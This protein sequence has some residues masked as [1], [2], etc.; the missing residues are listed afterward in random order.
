MVVT[1]SLTSILASYDRPSLPCND[2]LTPGLTQRLWQKYSHQM[3]KVFSPNVKSVL[4][5]C[6][7]NATLL[8]FPLS[9]TY[10]RLKESKNQRISQSID[11]FPFM[12]QSQNH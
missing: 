9:P 7:N 12:P 3:S 8:S 2:A 11:C 1:L 5:K 10:A 6:H 4:N